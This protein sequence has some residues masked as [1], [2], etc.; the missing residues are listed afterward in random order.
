LAKFRNWNHNLVNF[1]F[2]PDPRSPEYS[3]KED[4]SSRKSEVS[5]ISSS[6]LSNI[7]SVISRAVPWSQKQYGPIFEKLDDSISI[8]ESDIVAARNPWDHVIG[9]ECLWRN[10]YFHKITDRGLQLLRNERQIWPIKRFVWKSCLKIASEGNLK[11]GETLVK[12]PYCEKFP[13][14]PSFIPNG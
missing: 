12:H 4:I 5:S 2:D 7:K 9:P 1:F 14:S 10:S 13:N 8:S 3:V 6:E 11:A